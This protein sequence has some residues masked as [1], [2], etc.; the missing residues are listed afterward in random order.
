MILATNHYLLF[1][2]SK[3]ANAN[4][5]GSAA[6]SGGRW[7]FV[8][9]ALDSDKKLEATDFEASIHPDRLALLAVVRGLEALEQPS[10]V[11]LVTTSRY[12]SRGLRFGL[13]T[14]REQNYEWERFG[15]RIAIR[16]ADMWQR[17]D[18]ALKFH[19]V[20]ARLLQPELSPASSAGAYIQPSN[21]AESAQHQE[22]AATIATAPAANLNRQ[23][24]QRSGTAQ[25]HSKDWWELAESWRKWWRGRLQPS[26]ALMGT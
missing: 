5:A 9:E 15:E 14:W 6:E 22:L 3:Q 1:T 20:T 26:P 23:I 18:Q 10:Q 12:V 19:T 13:S 24:A 25:S 2:D 4:D 7:Q 21:E 16:N 8:L 11:R 17:V